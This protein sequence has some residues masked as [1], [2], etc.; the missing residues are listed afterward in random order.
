MTPERPTQWT[1]LGEHEVDGTRRAKW[2]VAHVRLPD[3]V[4]FEQ[5]VLRAPASAMALLIDAEDRVLL[6][7][8][9]RWVIDRWVWELPGGYCDPEEDPAVCAAR[10]VEEETGWRPTALKPLVAFQ[11]W[12]ATAD[13][14]QH[15]FV[16]YGATFTGAPVDVNEAEEIAWIPL[17]E[18]PERIAA[19]EIVGSASVIGLQAVLLDRLRG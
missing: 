4:E 9:H 15:L 1:I 11:P 16:S 8:R 5:Y 3:G 17:A 6:M 13:S 14:A 19:G 10:E 7:Y 18:I 12:V 2:S